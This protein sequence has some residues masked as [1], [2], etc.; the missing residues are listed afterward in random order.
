[1]DANN[2]QLFLLNLRPHLPKAA[3]ILLNNTSIHKAA[4]V[5]S[6]FALLQANGFKIL[7]LPP[8][9]PLLNPMEYTFAKV[10][11]IV[12]KAT[13]HNKEELQLTSATTLPSVLADDAWGWFLH[14]LSFYQ[15]CTLGLLF[16]GKPLMPTLCPAIALPSVA[17]WHQWEVATSA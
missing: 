17:Q 10:K 16:Q 11:K 12:H 7:F 9:S 1:M 15:Q 13:F 5:D 3:V 14:M 6:T 8:Y 4:L 2:F